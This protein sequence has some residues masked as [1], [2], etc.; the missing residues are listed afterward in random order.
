MFRNLVFL[1]GA[2]LLAACGGSSSSSDADS[3]RTANLTPVTVEFEATV[4]DSTLACNVDYA[5]VGAAATTI[6]I[7]DF[8]LFVHGIEFITVDQQSVALKLDSNVWQAQG[9]ALLD[10]EDATGACTGTAETHTVLTGTI[11]ADAADIAGI[12]FTVGIPE[13]LNHLEQAAVSPFNVTGMNWGW[14]NGFKFIRFDIEN[15][16]VHVGATGCVADSNGDV[17]CSNPNRPQTQFDNFDYQTQRIRID[18]AALVQDSDLSTDS[19]GAVGC[20]SGGT[21]PECNGVFTQLGLNLASGDN[22]PGLVQTVFSV[23][24]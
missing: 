21:D 7:K 23:A 1:P 8:R 9:V 15:W 5:N 10:F 6:Q 19:G 16:N 12:R 2:L 17:S 20:M 24:N 13:N 22:D 11:P 14:T 3:E 4:N 18:Y